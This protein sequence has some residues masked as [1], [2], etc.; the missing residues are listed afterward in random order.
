[1]KVTV[2][3][4]SPDGS[5]RDLQFQ[6]ATL[7]IG[8]ASRSDIAIGAW[9]PSLCVGDL[10]A[11]VEHDGF[12]FVTRNHAV[13]VQIT[14]PD[15]SR[16]RV[17][18]DVLY[19]RG[20][21]LVIGDDV[22]VR[23]EV[24]DIARRVWMRVTPCEPSSG[25]C[26]CAADAVLPLLSAIAVQHDMPSVVHALW[27]AFAGFVPCDGLRLAWRARDG[28]DWHSHCAGSDHATEGMLDR[29]LA[30]PSSPVTVL[31]EGSPIAIDDQQ[32]WAVALPF[33]SSNQAFGVIL[34]RCGLPGAV[35]LRQL[36]AVWLAARHALTSFLHR[37]ILI[38]LARSTFEENR[39]FRERELRN[40][41]FKPLVCQSDVM[42]QVQKDVL[43]WAQND[44]SV[45]LGGEAGTG[46]ELLARAL[47]HF[48]PRSRAMLIAQA[49]G[50][51]DEV[52]LDVELFG[53]V[54]KDEH[55]NEV[56]RQGVFELCDGGTVFLDDVHLL[57]VALQ[58]KLV[59]LLHERELFRGHDSAAQS[60]N[61]RVIAATHR[62]LMLLAGKG[63]FRYD[64]AISLGRQH[65]IV[66]A[67]RER[68]DDIPALLEVFIGDF[69][70]R[71]DRQV[72]GIEPE[73]LDWLQ[74]LDWP[75]NV[76][77]LLM[78]VERAVLR[79]SPDRTLLSILDFRF[80][81]SHARSV[82]QT[83]GA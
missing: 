49:C 10:V 61:V 73:A 45:L 24:V 4:H 31:L 50:A 2:R 9:I 34:V 25:Q 59:R 69:A 60:V 1:M 11:D 6:R 33:S 58:L 64:L 76:R 17:R 26:E 13:S 70:R 27:R 19:P 43:Q 82:D 72:T 68:K 81:D 41:L 15:G 3:L 79:C 21:S 28:R 38:E 57:P 36:E 5:A 63:L 40:H 42:R 7:N 62:D 55:G 67:L 80:T 71:Y 22:P 39:Y 54:R 77:E 52:T 74:S 35:A 32:G 66:P 48:G 44:V 14:F 18:P 56:V 46:K 65:V 53:E 29:L 20:A 47:H 12:R 8:G 37:E 78:V 16:E 51:L 23:L 30:E 75:G 83:H